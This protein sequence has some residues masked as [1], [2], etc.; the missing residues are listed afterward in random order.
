MKS[1]LKGGRVVKCVGVWGGVSVKCLN[2]VLQSGSLKSS[3]VTGP[4]SIVRPVRPWPDHILE[5]R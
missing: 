4:A 5:E 1:V 3:S 2:G